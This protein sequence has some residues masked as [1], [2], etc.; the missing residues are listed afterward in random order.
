MLNDKALHFESQWM[1][2]LAMFGGIVRL[3]MG[4]YSSVGTATNY[5][6]DVPRIEPRWGLDFS[7]PS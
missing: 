2:S 5:E 3:E 6:L 1:N 4:L 7:H